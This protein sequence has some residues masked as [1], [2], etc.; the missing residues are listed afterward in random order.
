MQDPDS[1][2]T[3][4]RY[5]LGITV[6]QALWIIR[7]FT[8]GGLPVPA[9]IGIF[10]LLAVCEMAVPLWAER[11]GMTRWHPHHVAER[12]SLFTIILLGESV[13][14]STVG[15]QSI[16]SAGSS[17]VEFVLLAVSG[18]ALLFGLW[19]IYFLE[20]AHEGLE[21]NRDRSFFWGYGHYVVF[22]SLAA[23][24]A[25]LE[26]GVEAVG[27]HVEAPPVV[28]AL[29][30]AVPVAV[31]LVAM[32]VLYR[33]LNGSTVIPPA[34]SLGAAVVVLLLALTAGALPLGVVALLITLTI[35][36]VITLTIMI[37]RPR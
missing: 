37:R 22:A 26:V 11:T 30:V 29:A 7:L 19:W 2:A 6:V 13:L 15:V 1:R 32:Q 28:V 9:Q 23:I 20:P 27:H 18:L 10:A 31:F 5:A 35:A 12:Y 14:A 33:P 24:G 17:S 4:L 21:R 3:A 25:G 36:A 16:V 8:V 34:V